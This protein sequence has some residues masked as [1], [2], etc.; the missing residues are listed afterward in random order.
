MSLPPLK[1]VISADTSGLDAGLNNALGSLKKFAG[2]AGIGLALRGLQNMVRDSMQVIDAQAKLARSVGGTTAGLQALARAGDRAGVQQSELAAAS[3]RLNQRL[4]QVIATGKGADDTFKALGLS[5]QQLARMDVDERFM[6]ISDAM[7]AAGMSSQEMSYHLR[8]LGIRQASVI[9]LIQG[10]S[11]E[12]ERSRKALEDFGVAVS[13]IDAAQI[14]RTNDALSEVGRVAE[15]LRNQIAISMA[16][17]IEAM[18]NAFTSAAMEGGAVHTIVQ[19]LVE[20]VPRL[21]TYLGTAAGA[22]AIYTGGLVAL[23]SAK[24]L[25]AAATNGLR[26]ALMRLGIP[27]LVIVAGELVHQFMRLVT[28]A[29]GFGEALN[30]LKDIAKGAFEYIIAQG[31]AIPPAIAA[32]WNDMKASFLAALGEMSWRWS[33]FLGDLA[34][35][36]RQIPLI[37]DEIADRLASSARSAAEG[38]ETMTAAAEGYRQTA[39][40][41]RDEAG[42]IQNQG[43]ERI[44]AAIQRLRDIM[45]GNDPDA[46]GAP[47]ATPGTEIGDNIAPG[48]GGAGKVTDD[49]EKRLEAVRQG[50][51]T[52]QE[53]INEWYEAGLQTL[54]EARERGLLTEQEFMEQR[55]RLEEE[56][57]NRLLKIKEQASQAELQMRKQTHDAAVGLLQQFGQRSRAAAVAALALQA[58][59][60]VQE[61]TASTAAAQVRAL[62]ELGP[63]AGPPAAAKIGAFGMAQKAIAVASAAL[64]GAGSGGSGGSIGSSGGSGGSTPAQP[65]MQQM[66]TQTLRFDFGGQNTMGMEQMVNLLNDA[67]DRGY[68]IRAV[69]A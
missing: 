43:A 42:E 37:G 48:V 19:G 58:A 3:T 61:I 24:W 31:R 4:G 11:G 10:G 9:T 47:S 50:L 2:A 38:W 54:I 66:P 21:A 57:Q 65:Q 20:I 8:E 59:Q 33:W 45:Q 32:V 35:G 34:M 15:G 23:A 18:A 25:A 17:S 64:R 63:I 27:A 6:A 28:S 14:E 30:V 1:A 52:E 26:V 40:S 5:A 53:V 51:L 49:L 13:E 46:P 22:I 29:G 36:M 39:Q 62:A 7:K 41:L 60:R 67:Y 69:M 56:H 55:E 68:R 16:P 44:G 12:I